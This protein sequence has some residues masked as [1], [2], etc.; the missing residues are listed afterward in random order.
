MDA[1][2]A[3]ISRAGLAL[4]IG[5][6][7]LLSGCSGSS[8]PAT[9]TAPAAE[10]APVETAAAVPAVLET[11]EDTWTPESLEDLLAPVALYPDEV[12]GPLLVASTNPQEVLDA[13][14]WRVE[15]EA[16]E[17][18]ELDVAAKSAGFTP[19]IRVLLQTPEV[20]DE[21]SSE[22]GWTTE[23]GQA[24]VNDQD[25]VLGA[26]QRLRLQAKEAG[27]LVSSDNMLVDDSTVEGERVVYLTSPDPERV[28]VPHYD[29]VTTYAPA[30]VS[31]S[32]DGHSTGT[33]VATALLA[34]GAGLVV[35]KLFDDDDDEWYDDDYYRPTYYGAPMPYYAHRPYRP[36]YAGYRP[37]Q[38]YIRP[39]A[40]RH[41]YYNANYV[42]V[43]PVNAGYWDRYD[44]RSFRHSQVRDA[45]SPISAARRERDDLRR[46]EEKHRKQ[47]KRR[48]PDR[49][50]REDSYGRARAPHDN[51][52]GEKHPKR[53]KSYKREK[54]RGRSDKGSDRGREGRGDSTRR[55][56]NEGR[57]REGRDARPGGSGAKR[58]SAGPRSKP[59][60]GGGR[61]G[62][63]RG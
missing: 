31:N 33:V 6:A 1:K 60:G 57:K 15:N 38:V 5:T 13:G 48:A 28:Y 45:R 56:D 46:Y 62:R 21:M 59:S 11:T 18:T 17:G 50:Q 24:Y 23:L 25:G 27:N 32:S 14:N 3:G 35:S 44:N 22:I 34:F 42:N 55:P 7:L 30:E 47:D 58:S 39:P 9:N 4:T 16:L 20:L 26:V 53:D 12:L 52:F 63:G 10:A 29:P 19:P 51:R 2:R 61:G 40:Y 54:D 36:V 49:S 8:T 43:R 37:A 41:S